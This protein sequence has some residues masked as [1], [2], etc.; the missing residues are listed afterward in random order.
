M[1]NELILDRITIEAPESPMKR[2]FPWTETQ[3]LQSEA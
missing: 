2:C 3:V 1:E